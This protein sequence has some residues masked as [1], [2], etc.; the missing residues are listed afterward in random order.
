[1]IRR[2][3][4]SFWPGLLLLHLGG[5]HLFDS[6]AIDKTCEDLAQ[7]CGEGGSAEG[8]DGAE[9][10]EGSDG[11]DG[12]DGSGTGDGADGGGLPDAD[13][14]GYAED[15]DCDD[16]DPNFHPG[17]AEVCD[18][19]EDCSGAADEAD[20]GLSDGEWVYTDH[21]EDGYGDPYTAL[22]TC[23]PESGEVLNGEDCDDGRTDVNPEASEICNDGL[24]NDCSGSSD[25]CLPISGRVDLAAAPTR[26]TATSVYL[27]Q[28]LSSADLT[29]DGQADLVV[30]DPQA[31]SSY[32]GHVYTMEGLGEPGDVAA[33]A[34]ASRVTGA[35]GDSFGL[36][37][38]TPADLTGDG[39]ADLVVLDGAFDLVVVDGPLPAGTSTVGT[40]WGSIRTSATYVGPQSLAW[41]DMD[42][43]GASELIFGD[44]G[45]GS[46]YQGAVYIFTAEDLDGATSLADA[47]A[48]IN[49]ESNYSYAGWVVAS[50]GDIDGDGA[51]ELAVAAPYLSVSGASYSGAVGFAGVGELTATTRFTDLA[52]GVYSETNY[53]TMGLT[54]DAG[55]VNGDGYGD[56]AVSAATADSYG[57]VRI[58]TGPLSG[59]A[60]ETSAWAG[61]YPTSTTTTSFGHGVSLEDFNGDGRIDV[62]VGDPYDSSIASYSGAMWIW[63]GLDG[64][65][66]DTSSM[67][68]MIYGASESTYVGYFGD[69]LPDFT[70]DGVAD[71][72]V[73]SMSEALGIWPGGGL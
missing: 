22:L 41:T 32:H 14:D 25:G 62:A 5:C 59:F 65:A 54:V 11:L 24:D 49:T 26:M 48:V 71:L 27:G 37:L 19:A 64:G 6:G 15:V 12:A 45:A 1:M 57:A 39:Y 42:G 50:A 36:A 34:A 16:A 8:A 33:G 13:G 63:Y 56:V 4:T 40:A 10:A 30:S 3:L 9:G 31:G 44:A 66:V 18:P 60:P 17:Q 69:L 73:G 67:D 72:V 38:T 35:A 7:G 55:D 70:Q 29:G 61:L 47:T 20:P 51:E 46:A 28:G 21:D 58:F 53:D 2:S 52:Y 23:S 68:A 43:D